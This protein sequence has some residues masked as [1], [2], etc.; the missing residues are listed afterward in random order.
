[1]EAIANKD[2]L[3]KKNNNKKKKQS[4]KKKERFRCQKKVLTKFISNYTIKHS[5]RYLYLSFRERER[6]KSIS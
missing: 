4:K 2:P 6:E 1:M 5:V 3:Q